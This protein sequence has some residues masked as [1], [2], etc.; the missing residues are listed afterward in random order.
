ML[1][2]EAS[3]SHALSIC[4]ERFFKEATDFESFGAA[5]R[6]LNLRIWHEV[7]A[8]NLKTAHVSEE[9]A[10]RSLKHFGFSGCRAG[11]LSVCLPVVLVRL[12]SDCLGPKKD[13][14]K[15]PSV[16]RT[17]LLPMDYPEFSIRDWIC[18]ELNYS[19]PQSKYRRKSGL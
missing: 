18:W 12:R 14:E 5:F 8:G 7:E 17:E 9:R 13:L 1:D 15:S 2:F 10:R 3:E 11:K 4:W 16:T 19:F 6:K